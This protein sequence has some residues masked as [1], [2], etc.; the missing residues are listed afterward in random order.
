MSSHSGWLGILKWSLAQSDDSDSPSKFEP[1]NDVSSS[2]IKNVGLLQLTSLFRLL[3]LCNQTCN[4]LVL[5]L[6]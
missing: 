2:R 5:T 3:L 1:M 4:P 6:T